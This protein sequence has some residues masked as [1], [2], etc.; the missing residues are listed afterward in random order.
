[1]VDVCVGIANIYSY[2]YVYLF[3]SNVK[4]KALS[5]FI[6]RKSASGISVLAN[7]MRT[8]KMTKLL[9]K[10]QQK[11]IMYVYVCMA[12]SISKICV[13][14]ETTTTT[15]NTHAHKQTHLSADVSCCG[16]KDA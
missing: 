3:L 5:I 15:E 14:C 12:T 10:F 7:R 4:G 1:M 8:N 9:N 6:V 11:E 2:I 13:G 16:L